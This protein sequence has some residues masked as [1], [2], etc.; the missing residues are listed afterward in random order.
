M[1]A[2]AQPAQVPITQETNALNEASE[3]DTITDAQMAYGDTQQ[4]PER[5]SNAEI[6]HRFNE[7]RRELLDDRARTIDWWLI[8]ITVFLGLLTLLAALAG[9]VGYLEFRRVRE[10][11][12]EAVGQAQESAK[13]AKRFVEE[14]EQIRDKSN[15][16]Y[17]DMTAE[18]A[19]G[20]PAAEEKAEAVSKDPTASH[21]D[22]AV[23][24]AIS[25][26]QEGKIEAAI[27]IWQGIAD[28]NEEI[29]NELAGR[30]W[31]SVGYLEGEREGKTN[32]EKAL[33]AYDRAIQ[34]NPV[35]A[36]AYNNRGNAK[37]GL[38]RYEDAIADYNQAIKLNP[39]LSEAYN[40]RGDTK[41]KIGQYE[42]AI[43]DCT[44]AIELS[45]NH[46]EAYN[47]RGNAKDGL[48]RYEDAIADYNQAIKLNPS[49]SE[50]YNNRGDTKAKIGQYEGA[51]A[52]CTRAI[53]LSPNDALAYINRGRAKAKLD[54][55]A[56]A[57]AD[58]EKALE[59]AK[60]AEDAETV[61]IVE[62]NLRELED[63]ETT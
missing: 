18:K 6:D 31:F 56:E 1:I 44:R 55:I 24:R 14:I 59:I 13:E 43:A 11:G 9:I 53:E 48:G 26:K 42:G 28:S 50:A 63:S 60:K 47:N 35:L 4:A 15:E 32:L 29:D 20:D 19:V 52:D 38:G 23:A 3:A 25:L 2:L 8:G 27:R 37:D 40:N 49:L 41:A 61:S 22:K 12:L 36:E 51:I 39:S 57:R 30:G 54:R 62:K 16:Y 34:L 5:Y 7:I 10:Q 17:Q 33:L 46:A 58:F 45:P 21:M